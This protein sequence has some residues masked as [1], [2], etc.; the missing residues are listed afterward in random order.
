MLKFKWKNKAIRS[1]PLTDKLITLFG[2]TGI[3][4]V[5]NYLVSIQDNINI[6]IR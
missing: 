6:F 1:T 2:T 5:I 4:V 3:I